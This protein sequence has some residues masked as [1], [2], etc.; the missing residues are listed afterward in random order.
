MVG[1]YSLVNAWGNTEFFRYGGFYF[2]VA[3]RHSQLHVGETL[4]ALIRGSSKCYVIKTKC[5]N[6]YQ[7]L[8]SEK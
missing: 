1:R 2:A 4:R 8:K 6:M 5:L 3:V 7:M